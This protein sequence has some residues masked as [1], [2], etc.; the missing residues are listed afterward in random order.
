MGT[1]HPKNA[2]Q[3]QRLLTAEHWVCVE[4]ARY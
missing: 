2:A 3:K 1:L 4:R